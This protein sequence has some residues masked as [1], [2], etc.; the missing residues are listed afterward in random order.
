MFPCEQQSQDTIIA[1]KYFA[2]LKSFGNK[3]FV[4][5]FDET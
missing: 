5:D 2:E 3:L 1:G 4:S